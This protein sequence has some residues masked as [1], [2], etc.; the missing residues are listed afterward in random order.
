MKTINF[1]EGNLARF[2]LGAAVGYLFAVLAFVAVTSLAILD[3]LQRREAVAA[4]DDILARLEGRHSPAPRNVDAGEVSQTSGSSFLEGPTLT[5]AGAALQQRVVG[6]ISR[7]GGSISSSQVDLL[8]VRSRDGFI[9]VA[10]NCEVD[11]TSLQKLLYDLEAGTPYLFVDQL[12]AQAPEN[13]T[14][15]LTGRLRILISVSGKW[16]GVK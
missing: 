9:S 16:Q 14:G 10:T 7:V 13:T 1:I 6:A 3:V 12:V 11:Q 4:N 2:P 5:V 8:G 15:A